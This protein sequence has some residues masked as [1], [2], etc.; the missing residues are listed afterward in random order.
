MKLI[1]VGV[2]ELTISMP[3]LHI[4][5]L[6]SVNDVARIGA[7]YKHNGPTPFTYCARNTS[8]VIPCNAFSAMYP[9]AF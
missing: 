9:P 5:S 2:D 1:L 6:F 8:N 7:L 4:Q 3:P